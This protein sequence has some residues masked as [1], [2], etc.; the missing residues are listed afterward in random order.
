MTS[1]RRST[2]RRLRAACLGLALALPLGC[3]A[4]SHTPAGGAGTSGSGAGGAS[5]SFGGDLTVATANGR[6]HDGSLKCRKVDCPADSSPSTTSVSGVVYDPAGRVPLYNAVV[7]VVNPDT[8]LHALGQ[9]VQCEDCSANF[10]PSA[11]AVTL[12]G[13]DGSF[14]LTDMPTGKDVPLIVQLGKWRRV[15]SIPYVAPCTDT[16]LPRELTR[17]PRNSS[18]GSLPKI[19]VTTGGSDALECLLKKI[20]VDVD[21]FTPDSGDGRVNL[22]AGYGAAKAMV[23]RGASVPLRPA[24]ELWADANRMLDYDMLLMGCEGDDNLWNPPTDS[25]FPPDAI[26]RP[27]SMA[28]EVRKYADLGGRI[29]GSHWHHRWIGSDNS[30][31]DDPYPPVAVFAKTAKDI[32]DVTVSVDTTFPKGSAFSDWL[33]AVGASA[34]P[35]ELSVVKAEHSVNSVDAKL[36]RRWI[37]GTD[38]GGKPD[39]SRVPEMVQYFSF[40]TPVGERECGRMVFSDVHVSFGGGAWAEKLFPERCS[41]SPDDELSPQE[42]ALE[43]M[44]F[45]L[46]SCIQKEDDE[47]S[48]PITVVK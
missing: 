3:S 42:K 10:P 45:D 33:V 41:V 21:E 13:A 29:F 22:F 23:S 37:F 39:S 40:T 20:G 18:E 35:G 19:A 16:P 26:E 11:T 9:R 46:S 34:T 15:V 36:A 4:S 25:K 30:T 27:A 43:F 44:I 1:R 8:D 6:C 2:E 28:L 31:P 38:P 48:S 32:G 7:Y 5:P 17:L 47:V 24:E 14:R 12:S